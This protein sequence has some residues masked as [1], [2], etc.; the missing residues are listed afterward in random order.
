MPKYTLNRNFTLRTTSGV[1]AFAKGVETHVPPHMEREAV[2]IGAEIVNGQ[3]PSL[4][5]SDNALPK[6]PEGADRREQILTAIALIVDRNDAEDFT[7]SGSPSVKAVS[8]VLDFNVERAELAEA[9]AEFKA[10]ANEAV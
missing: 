4:V 1:I 3:A 7:G 8:K 9:W 2:A 10:K 5:P 6:V